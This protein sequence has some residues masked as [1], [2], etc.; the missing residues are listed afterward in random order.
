ML[1]SYPALGS[2]TVI[3]INAVGYDVDGSNHPE[4]TQPL[5][6]ACSGDGISNGLSLA[7]QNFSA[8]AR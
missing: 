4:A 6:D 2:M 8:R 5:P 3:G 7:A 1:S